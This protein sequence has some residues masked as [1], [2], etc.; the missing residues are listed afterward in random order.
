MEIFLELAKFNDIKYY[1]IPHKYYLGDQQLTSVTTIIGKY[2]EPFDEEFWSLYKALEEVVLN[3]NGYGTW[4]NIKRK[5]LQDKNSILNW[6]DKYDSEVVLVEQKKIILDWDITN[7]FACER[8]S[9]L[10][11]YAENYLQNKIFDDSLVPPVLK[12]QF[13]NFYNL[14]FNKLIPVKCELIVYD[15]E[16]G[17]SGMIDLLVFNVKSGKYQLWDHKTNKEFSH[18]SE[19]D[20]RLKTPVDNLHECKLDVYSLQLSLYKYI[21]EKNTNIK[22]DDSYIIWYN[23]NNPNFEIIRCKNLEREVKLMLDHALENKL[24][25]SVK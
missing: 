8:G 11:N 6:V 19:Y 2:E 5:I 13:L 23:E 14:T 22:L 7:K 20:S 3:K 18:T 15:K 16:Y 24:L 17:L 12:Q 4:G 9:I 1:D 10:H 21:I 25:K